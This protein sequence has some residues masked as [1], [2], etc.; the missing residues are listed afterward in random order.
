MPR[1]TLVVA[2][3]TLIIVLAGLPTITATLER[4]GMIPL[5]RTIRTDYLTGTAMVVIATLLIL[6]PSQRSRAWFASYRCPTC[7][8]PLNSRG[9][10]CPLCGSRL[11]R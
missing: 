3:V 10:Y 6:T 2:M 5:A 8:S 7:E 4:V 9:K 11:P 1:K